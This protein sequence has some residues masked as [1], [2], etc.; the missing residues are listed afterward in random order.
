MSPAD[1]RTH[2]YNSEYAR[3]DPAYAQKRPASNA[4]FVAMLFGAH[5]DTLRVRDFAAAA[6]TLPSAC[7]GAV[8]RPATPMIHSCPAST[9]CRTAPTT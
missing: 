3:L 9:R 4:D 1:F 5:K 6:A 7:A 2:I 8:L